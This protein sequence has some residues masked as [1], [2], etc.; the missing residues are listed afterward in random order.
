MTQQEALETSGTARWSGVVG[1]ER[2]H[3]DTEVLVERLFAEML[4]VPGLPRTASVFDLGLDSVWVTVACARLEQMTGVRVRFTQIFRTPTVAELAAWIDANR[5][6]AS[7][8]AGVPAEPSAGEGDEL[9]AISPIQAESV[10]QEIVV[11][12]AWWF[13]SEIDATALES[14]ATDVHRRHQALHAR[15]LSGP[16]LGLAE[17]P[18]DPGRVEFHRLGDEDT[19][20]AAIEALRRTLR[21]PL[22]VD[23][24]KVWRCVLVRSGQSGRTLFGLAVDHS[25]FDGRSWDIVTAELPVAYA[26]RVAGR[27]PR[28]PGRTASLAEMACDFRRQL[29]SPDIEAQRQ[30]WRDELRDLPVCQFPRLRNEAAQTPPKADG[31]RYTALGPAVLRSFLVPESHLRHWNDYARNNGMPSSV[32]VAAVYVESLVRAGALPDFAMMVPIANNSGEVI[33][34]TVTNRVGTILLRPNGPSRSGPH[35]L[36]RMRESYQQAMAARDALLAPKDLADV[37]SGAEGTIPLDRMVA[38]NYNSTPSLSL[39]GVDGTLVTE[40]TAFATKTFFVVMLLVTPSP[41]GLHIGLQVRTD[42]HDAGLVDQIKQH[43]LEIIEAGPERLE[44][45]GA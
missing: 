36:A 30:Y 24:G 18:A 45:G 19:D 14:A 22:R 5:D 25:G 32:A 43:F 12:I 37:L 33:D 23:E 44:S 27:T 21:T 38:L 40:G 10:P 41:E 9:V 4:D 6:K 3:G 15:Y 16:D 13:D 39:S 17:V 31:S 34:R 42:L 29:T 8:D 26:A 1:E 28:W 7:N 20:Q 2:P 35:L 11:E